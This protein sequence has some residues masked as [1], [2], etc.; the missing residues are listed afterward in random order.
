MKVF[1]HM[2]AL[3]L[4]VL[5][6]PA[7]VAQAFAFPQYAS[8]AQVDEECQRLLAEQKQTDQR[9]AQPADD[10]DRRMLQ[11]RLDGETGRRYRDSVLANGGQVAPDELLKQFLGRA[12]DSR[13]FFESLNRQ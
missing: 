6:A 10:I 11:D 3:C 7:A 8:A 2:L 4:A 12:S 13:A 9:L 1:L 5:C